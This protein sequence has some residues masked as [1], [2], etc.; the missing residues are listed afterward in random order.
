M[1]LLENGYQLQQKFLVEKEPKS[2]APT[3]RAE[4]VLD[5]ARQ[6]FLIDKETNNLPIELLE[7]VYKLPERENEKSYVYVSDALLNIKEKYP[8]LSKILEPSFVLRGEKWHQKASY[9]MK[10]AGKVI[11]HE[12]SIFTMITISLLAALH[13][14]KIPLPSDYS[15]IAQCCAVL[16]SLFKILS[17]PQ[18]FI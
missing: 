16:Y 13:H 2:D 15:S 3:F 9:F 14:N 4:K 10:K 8:Y 12:L 5:V 6:Q 18:P 7:I 1:R 11:F 17:T